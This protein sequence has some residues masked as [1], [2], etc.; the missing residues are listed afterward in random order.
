LCNLITVNGQQTDLFP[1]FYLNIC[2]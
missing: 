1:M 2:N